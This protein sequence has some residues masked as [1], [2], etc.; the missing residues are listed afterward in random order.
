MAS[1]L[2]PFLKVILKGK[3][4]GFFSSHFELLIQH[5]MSL[6]ESTLLKFLPHVSHCCI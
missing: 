6:N 1:D 3:L 2:I 5:G 4:Q